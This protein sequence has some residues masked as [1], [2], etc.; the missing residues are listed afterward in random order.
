KVR[1]INT[2]C[3]DVCARGL[4]TVVIDPQ[5]DDEPAEA[6]VVDPCADRETLYRRIVERLTYTTREP[7]APERSLRRLHCSPVARSAAARA[8]QGSAPLPPGRPQAPA[9]RESR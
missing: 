9:T 8:G 3:M 4:V 1:A 7:S 5:R 6:F 2:S